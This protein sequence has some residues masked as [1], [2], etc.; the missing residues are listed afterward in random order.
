[1]QYLAK[2]KL[3]IIIG[4]GVLVLAIIIVIVSSI[5]SNNNKKTVVISSYTDA[6][7]G[8]LIDNSNRNP[9]N[10]GGKNT[11]TI[12]IGL[13]SLKNPP[14]GTYF[15]IT[16]QQIQT[17]RDDLTTKGIKSLSDYSNIVKF[18]NPSS[19][20]PDGII[21]ADLKYNES[22][23]NAKIHIILYSFRE[24]SYTILLD[25][26]VIYTSDKLSTFYGDVD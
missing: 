9:E 17:F 1:M 23:P 14:D 21:I 22:K 15:L 24:L 20:N 12:V 16:D 5:V 11:P 3:F 4:V 19:D 8:E 13:T 26:K 6:D 2:N 18:L 7:T 25:N 10:D